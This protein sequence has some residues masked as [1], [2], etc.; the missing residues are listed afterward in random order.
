MKHLKAPLIWLLA[1]AI[2]I[3]LSATV[4]ADDRSEAIPFDVNENGETY[5]DYFQAASAGYTPDLIYA[6]GENGIFGYVRASDLEEPM[7]ESPEAALVLQ[8]ERKASGYTGHFINLYD[9]DG[10]TIIGRFFVSAG[11]LDSAATTA[12]SSLIESADTTLTNSVCTVTGCSTIQQIS[13]GVV[14]GA[15]L[16]SN[17]SLGAGE[18]GLKIMLYSADSYALVNSYGYDYSEDPG[19]EFVVSK[20]VH[21]DSG[22][23]YASGIGRVY[24]RNSQVYGNL[25]LKKTAYCDI[26]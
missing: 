20:V 14:Y 12:R 17:V 18:L 2:L 6:Q 24:D 16:E 21:T 19:D 11:Y 3:S 8:A 13:T 22:V 23:Y 4:F 15:R 1:V 25:G 10:V 5:G 9:A 7:P 26:D